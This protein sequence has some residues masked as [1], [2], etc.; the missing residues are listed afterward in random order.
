MVAPAGHNTHLKNRGKGGE[1]EE[2]EQEE[3]EEEKEEVE[4]LV[5]LCSVQRL[6]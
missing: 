4:Q 6:S 2:D 5:K 1:V 3:E